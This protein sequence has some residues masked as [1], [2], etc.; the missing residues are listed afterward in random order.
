MYSKWSRCKAATFLLTC[1]AGMTGADAAAQDYP[2]PGNTRFIQVPRITATGLAAGVVRDPLAGPGYRI[3]TTPPVIDGRLDDSA[4][5]Q[6]SVAQEFWI[7]DQQRPPAEQTEVLV[8]ADD[9]NL[10]FGFRVHDA[11]PEA[12]EAIQTRRDAGLGFDDQVAVELDSYFNRRDISRF[13]VSA[14]GVQDDAIAGGR[15]AKIEWKGDWSAAATRTDYGWSA[16]IAIPFSILNYQEGDTTFGVNFLRYQNRSQEWSRW[17]DVTPRNLP[18]QMGQLNGLVLPPAS[19]KQPWTVMPYALV[20]WNI[21]DKEGD[22]KNRLATV[23]VDL[24]YQP[25]P[26]LTGLLS[27][28]PD[29]SQVERQIT[30]INF[31]Y[32][33]KFRADVRPFFVEGNTYFGPSNYFYSNRVPD[34]DYGGRAFGRLGNTQF[35]AFAV[36]APN[37][38][39]D[40]AL[41]VLQELDPTHSLSAM[42][43]GTDNPDLRNMLAAGQFSGRR[44][45]GLNYALDAAMTDTSGPRGQG[46]YLSGALGWK[47][48]YWSAGAV[49]DRYTADYFP[50]AALLGSDLPGTEGVRAFGSYYREES[51]GPWRALRGDLVFTYRETDRDQL[52]IRNWY[53]GGSMEFHNQVRAGVFRYQ[54]PYRPVTAIP[55]IFSATINDDE[56]WN[57]ALDLNTRSSRFAYGLAYS[58]GSLGGGDYDYGFAYAWWRP[59]NTLYLSISGERL[60]NFG[61]SDQVVVNGQWDVTPLDSFSTRYIAR[62]GFDFFR[63]AYGRRVRRGVDIFTV[64]DN[65]AFLAATFSVKLLLTY[66]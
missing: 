11:R 49:A 57:A 40:Y 33:E 55:G 26:D 22:I 45:S 1:L 34:F 5:A 19:A 12:I 10:Y 20:G 23:G 39:T 43:V 8:L 13:S 24:R 64:Y 31:S 37:D 48:N 46:N 42:V 14:N 30:D 25:R 52:Q 53:G 21:P 58:W 16:E 9:R 65:D 18:E 51:G 3:V 28:N 35:G 41:R 62:D 17:A 59:I 15:S 60:D 47:A 7:S 66:P 6:A 63:L 38:R 27:L 61:E 4:W 29:F 56:Y 2:P 54:G 50:A 32:V 36:K 44:A